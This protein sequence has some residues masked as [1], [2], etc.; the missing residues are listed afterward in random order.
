MKRG[1]ASI[2]KE[3]IPAKKRGAVIDIIKKSPVRKR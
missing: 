3:F 1:I 2:E